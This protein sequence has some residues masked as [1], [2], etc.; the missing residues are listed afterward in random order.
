MINW[1]TSGGKNWPCMS[2][3][4]LAW[5]VVGA[6]QCPGVKTKDGGMIYPLSLAHELNPNVL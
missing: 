2:G 6:G 1:P 5:A 4:C 3:P